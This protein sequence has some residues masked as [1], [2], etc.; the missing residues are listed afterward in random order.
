MSTVPAPSTVSAVVLN[1]D[2]RELLQVILPSLARQSYGAIETIVVDNGSHDDS[3]EW[4][5]REWPQ[6]E[7]S[8]S[9]RT[10]ASRPL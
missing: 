10:S 6:V 9:P 3:V 7:L 2:G 4:L 1:Y 5:R 8:R